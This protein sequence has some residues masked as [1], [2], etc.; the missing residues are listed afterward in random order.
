[1]KK[2]LTALAEDRVLS[3]I[4]KEIVIKTAVCSVFRCGAGFVDWT[5][6]E[7]ED[8]SKLWIRAYKQAWTLSGS[9]DSSPMI[10]SVDD[11]GRGRSSAVDLWTREVY[12]VLE[13]CVGLPCEISQITTHYPQ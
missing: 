11:G 13:Q 8:I 12:E 1:M 2:R 6:T 5:R 10:L 7:L 9:I 4:E 3:R